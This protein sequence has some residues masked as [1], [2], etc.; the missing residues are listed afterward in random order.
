[1]WIR[2]NGF[3]IWIFLSDNSMLMSAELNIPANCSN[4]YHNVGT[5]NIFTEVGAAG[6]LV[7]KACDQFRDFFCE[8][9]TSFLY[10]AYFQK[11]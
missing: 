8:L 10:D 3:L 4:C 6:T 11:V 9:L 2:I 5:A 1:M 7:E